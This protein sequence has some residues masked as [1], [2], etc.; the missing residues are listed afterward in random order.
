M[1]SQCSRNR[2]VSFVRLRSIGSCLPGRLFREAPVSILGVRQ[3]TASQCLLLGGAGVLRLVEEVLML[4]YITWLR[5][6]Q[7]N[8]LHLG[9]PIS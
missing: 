6:A 8:W 9:L 3:V 5:Q 4:L 1:S 7:V 2:S